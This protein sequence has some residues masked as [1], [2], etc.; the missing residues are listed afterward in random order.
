IKLKNLIKMKKHYILKIV[1]LLFLTTVQSQETW[2]KLS[3]FN[4]ANSVAW[5][6]SG[7]NNLNYAITADRWIYYSDTEVQ[8]WEPF[9]DVPSYFNAGSIKASQTTNRV[10]CLTSSSGLAYTDNFGQNWQTTSI[11]IIN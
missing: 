3:S 1:F 2:H 6:S 9:I 11:G 5:M 4:D 8:S 7:H 10:F